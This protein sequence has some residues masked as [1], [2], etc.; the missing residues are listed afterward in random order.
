MK[1]GS[2]CRSFLVRIAGCAAIAVPRNPVQLRLTGL[3]ILLSD[4]K[5]AATDIVK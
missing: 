5:P 3:G 1:A 2:M 4:N